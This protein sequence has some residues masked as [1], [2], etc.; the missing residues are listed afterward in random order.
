MQVVLSGSGAG[1]R[2]RVVARVHLGDRQGGRLLCASRCLGDSTHS[3]PQ[4]TAAGRNLITVFSTVNN[5]REIFFREGG[6]A[7]GTRPSFRATDDAPW[8]VPPKRVAVAR[9]QSC[10]GKTP[11]FMRFVRNAAGVAAPAC[12][13]GGRLAHA[14]PDSARDR[15]GRVGTG[16]RRTHRMA[17][18]NT[19]IAPI[20]AK[21]TGRPGAAGRC[22]RW[23]RGFRR[24]HPRRQWAAS[25]RSSAYGS[26]SSIS[27]TWPGSSTS[28]TYSQPSPYASS[29]IVSGL[30]ASAVLTSTTVPLTGLYTSHA[31]F[32][33]S[34]TALAAPASTRS[35]TLGS[36]T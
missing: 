16:C 19:P 1:F 6:A 24:P 31:A 23:H 10:C 8:T 4:E 9:G 21:K 12:I 25:S 3:R 36:S 32:T 15:S 34:T 17:R 33:D 5:P 7:T 14:R 20:C 29:L 27:F 26:G 2:G 11:C 13:A 35:P 18:R 30:S 22:S 28:T